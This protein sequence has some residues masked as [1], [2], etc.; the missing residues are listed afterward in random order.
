[1]EKEAEGAGQDSKALKLEIAR[2][3]GSH[4]SPRD[5]VIYH[6]NSELSFHH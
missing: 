1:M 5:G 3:R 4:S 6:E 2:S